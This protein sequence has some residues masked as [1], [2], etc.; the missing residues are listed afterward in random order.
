MSIRFDKKLILHK[1][2][3]LAV[4]IQLFCYFGDADD[5]VTN[6]CNCLYK[7]DTRY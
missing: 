2:H 6:L 1:H 5:V 7:T 4:N 3:D